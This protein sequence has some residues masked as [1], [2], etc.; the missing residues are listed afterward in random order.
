[1]SDTPTAVGPASLTE[2]AVMKALGR[3][4]DPELGCSVVDLG[5][6]YGLAIAEGDVQVSMTMTT[7]AC[8]L[9]DYLASEAEMA[10]R[11]DV[12]GW[13]SVRVELVWEPAWDPSRMSAAARDQLKW[14]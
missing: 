5:L 9:G 7:A 11:R 1:M 13:R 4:I 2:D 8:P 12:Q 10:I 3:V 14:G 6:I